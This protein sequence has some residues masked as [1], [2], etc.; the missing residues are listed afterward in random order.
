[1]KYLLLSVLMCITVS[2]HSQTAG[3]VFFSENGEKFTVTMNGLQK[4][5]TP[6]TQVK[7]NNIYGAPYLVKITFADT[8]LGVID[9]KVTA[10]D[11]KERTYVIRLRKVSESEKGIKKAGV[12]IGRTIEGGDKKEAAAKKEQ[13]NNTNSMYV[14]K[15]LSETALA[16]QTQQTVV[17]ATA[18]GTTPASDY[19]EPASSNKCSIPMNDGTF[20]AAV[21]S[22]DQIESQNTRIT[23]AKQLIHNNC[24][25]CNQVRQLI[26]L[27]SLEESRLEI[28]K[29]AYDHT[30]DKQNYYKVND[31]FTFE[32]SVDELNRYIKGRK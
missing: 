1:M 18:A 25:S 9:E 27:F 31:T 19:P 23:E 32:A 11:D 5:D 29:Y 21:K 2:V 10:T 7:V 15:F 12:D 26:L 28:A 30:F 24:L 14:L 16:E 4:N 13:I 22:F 3:L 8:S 6:Q 17:K 20:A